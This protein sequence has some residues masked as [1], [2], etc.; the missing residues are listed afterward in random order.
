[1]TRPCLSALALSAGLLAGGA[2]L[3]AQTSPSDRAARAADRPPVEAE[4]PDVPPKDVPEITIVQPA[5]L[6]P[7]P[8]PAP[9]PR[10]ASDT[11]R[12]AA[13]LRA[14]PHRSADEMVL[15]VP[16]AFVTQHSGEGKA[17]QIFYRGFDAVH[18]QDIEIWAGGAPV[19]D[20]SNLHGQ[21]Y[22]DLHFLP[23]EIVHSLHATPG[24]YD[25]RQGDFA[26][27]G[28]LRFSLGYDRPGVTLK[29]GAGSHGTQRYFLAYRPPGASDARFAAVEFHRTDG[30]GPSRAARRASAV[31]QTVVTLADG[32]ALRL[33]VTGHA[34]RFASAGVLPLAAIEDGAA[35]PFATL[36]PTQGGASARTQ[37]V[38]ELT[39][40][41]AG[42]TF[43]LTSY[44]VLRSLR[45][46]HNFT[47]YLTG[48][49]GDSQQQLNDDLAVG[50]TG[51]YRATRRWLSP[52]DA[53]EAGFFVRSD[54]IEQSQKQLSIVD[55]R[56]VADQVDAAVRAHDVAGYLDVEIH[57]ASRLTLRGG[58]RFDALAYLVRDDGARAAGQARSAQG[59]HVGRKGTADVRLAG[60]LHAI[61]SYGEGFRSP[62]A[63]SLSDG[64]SAPFT[65][66]R[67]H[68][69]GLRWHA[70]RLTASLAAFHTRLSDDLVFDQ[71]TVRNERVPGTRRTGLA[72]DAAAL[73][74]GWLRAGAG[75]T[76]TRSVFAAGD[77]RYRAGDLVPYAP[78]WVARADL[79][80]ERRLFPWRG[81]PVRGRCGLGLS[82]LAWRPLP[83]G[84][85]GHDVVL[86][87]ATLGARW[88]A[89]EISVDV[90]N[91]LGARWYDGQFLY[92][93]R[94]ERAQ[95]ASLVP[96]RH[97]TA[98]APRMVLASLALTL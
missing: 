9:Q 78:Q 69:A 6:P 12:D 56:V 4:P 43:G 44:A 14:A 1:M 36:D 77:A 72:L 16:G 23:V 34:G 25:P 92:A 7:P 42:A 48:P 79:L 61:A 47:G 63:R 40:G 86:A 46:R 27:A 88:S 21:G 70:S 51:F 81:G 41:D 29:A 60:A 24:T 20:V 22:A 71:A 91:L 75:A 74:G 83:Y 90:T 84:Q 3:R 5:E 98:G 31:A 33:L 97:V 58:A 82:H 67:S 19:N 39:G 18:G 89:L 73:L 54:W 87:D 49:D 66:V 28:T 52:E 17:Y 53:I 11:V 32:L 38:A 50:A 2:E 30:F 68:E 45:L 13:I 85:W 10:S 96:Q 94:W 65:R 93:S 26:V 80:A 95:A 37:A 55:N 15:L 59:L 8:P 35:D 76:Y 62:Q 64:E 57:P